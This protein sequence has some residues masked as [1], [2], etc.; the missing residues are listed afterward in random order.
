MRYAKV[1]L[2]SIASLAL[3]VWSDS[4]RGQITSVAPLTLIR[5]GRVFDSEQGVFLPARD[6]IVKGNLIES[7]GENLPVPKDARVVD[8]QRYTVLPGLIDGRYR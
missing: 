6:I 3:L 4:S 5:A 1:M 2:V 7:I 8:L